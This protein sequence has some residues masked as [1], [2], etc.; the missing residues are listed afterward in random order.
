LRIAVT[1]VPVRRVVATGVA[2]SASRV[3][4]VVSRAAGQRGVAAGRAQL[5][6][7]EH[8]AGAVDARPAEPAEQLLRPAADEQSAD[9]APQGECSKSPAVL[10]R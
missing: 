10:P 8:A 2:P 5:E 6:V 1:L 4:P 9:Q 7:L 3:P